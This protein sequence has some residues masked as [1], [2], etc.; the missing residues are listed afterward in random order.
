[1]Q[2]IPVRSA[3]AIASVA[4]VVAACA[5]YAASSSSGA[6]AA[7]TSSA[8]AM[9]VV[10][11]AAGQELGT[12]TIAETSGGLSTTG[13][14]R[15]LAPGVHGIH[16]HTVGMCDGTF[17][18]A[19][20]HWN[21]TAHQHGFDNPQGPHDGDMQNV[22]VGADSTVT[23]SV[24]TKGGTLRG[25]NGLLDPD[26]AAVVVHAGPDDYKTDPAGNSGARVA[27]GVARAS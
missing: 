4:V 13:T 1:M 11:D 20:G 7:S 25:A 16:L 6:A 21:P 18:S 10:H 12:L 26:G 8:V 17:T 19:G 22:T 24:T 23:V 27:C 2:R 3:L 5:Q 15:G 14:L 9:A